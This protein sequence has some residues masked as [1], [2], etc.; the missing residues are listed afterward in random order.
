MYFESNWAGGCSFSQ[1]L[2]PNGIK[3][4]LGDYG[5]ILSRKVYQLTFFKKHFYNENPGWTIHK[6]GQYVFLSWNSGFGFTMI[7]EM[8]VLSILYYIY[9]HLN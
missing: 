9:S 3:I 5:E 4:I 8:V 6:L 2:E 1:K 7:N